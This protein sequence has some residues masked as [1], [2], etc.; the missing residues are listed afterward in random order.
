MLN[1]VGRNASRIRNELKV[2]IDFANS[3]VK[4]LLLST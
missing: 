3:G 1:F 2:Y 4:Y